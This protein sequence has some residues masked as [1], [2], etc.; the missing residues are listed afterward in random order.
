METD[1]ERQDL[2]MQLRNSRE[3]TILVSGASGIVGYG[4]LKSL[5]KSGCKLIGTT[6]YE[7]SPANCFADFVEIVPLTWENTYLASLTD[8]I[9]RYQINMII[10]GIESD[11][12]VWNKNRRRIEKTGVKVLLNNYDL[13]ETCLDKWIFY[14]KLKSAGFKNCITTSIIPDAN[15]FELPFIIKPR[16]GYGSKGVIKIET[17]DSFEKYKDDIG[18]ILIMQEYVG[19]D[20]EEYTI[21]AFFDRNS[22]MRSHIS[23][24]RKLSK[25]GFT[26][27]AEVVYQEDLLEVIAE[28]SRIF[29]PVGPTN[30]QFRRHNGTWKLLEINPRISSSTSIRAAFGYNEAEMCIDYFL[31]GKEINQPVIRFGKAIRYVEDYILYDSNNI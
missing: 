11:M 15:Q 30:F 19:S 3:Y 22:N 12:S 16:C 20:D 8:I 31:E 26:E 9:D 13:I 17:I 6:I 18:K 5:K 7:E 29:K 21:S 1:L 25:N 14:Q 23:M 27:I 28:L 4:I 2:D 24:R 10:P